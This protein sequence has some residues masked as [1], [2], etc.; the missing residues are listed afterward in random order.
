MKKQ[1]AAKPTDLIQKFPIVHSF[2]E[3]A[4]TYILLAKN[5]KLKVF[6]VRPNG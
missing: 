3:E 4:L 5:F 2:T 6:P 1:F